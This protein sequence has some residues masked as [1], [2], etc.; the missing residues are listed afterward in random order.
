MGLKYD[1]VRV[2]VHLRRPKMF[3]YADG[4]R[5]QSPFLVAVFE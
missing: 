3:P 1:T 5:D 2:N 4:N